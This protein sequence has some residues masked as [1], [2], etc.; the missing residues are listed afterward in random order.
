MWRR[1]VDL[2]FNRLEALSSV[3]PLS[4]LR[5]LSL[6]GNMLDSLSGWPPLCS[7]TWLS[8]AS[9]RLSSL[10]GEASLS[11]LALSIWLCKSSSLKATLPCTPIAWVCPQGFSRSRLWKPSSWATMNAPAWKVYSSVPSSQGWMR[12][13]TGFQQSLTHPCTICVTCRWLTTGDIAGF[14]YSGHWHNYMCRGV[15]RAVK[16]C[17]TSRRLR[18]TIHGP[19]LIAAM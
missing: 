13:R 10:Q 18:M 16:A 5:Q 4:N 7:L 3:P 11:M 12:L 14:C 1:H 2:S 9:N 6:E 17:L 8:L 19:Q 15:M